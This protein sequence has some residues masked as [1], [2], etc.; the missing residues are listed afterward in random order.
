MVDMRI[1]KIITLLVLAALSVAGILFLLTHGGQENSGT[2][3]VVINE[4]MTKNTDAVPDENGEFYDWVELHNASAGE[5]D[6]S[7]YGFSDTKTEPTKWTFP[8]GTKIAA[9]GYLIVYCSGKNNGMHTNFKLSAKGDD[10]VLSDSSGN[11]IDAITLRSVDVGYTLAR[12]ADDPSQWMVSKPTPGFPNSD[13]GFA[14]YEAQQTAGDANGLYLNELMASNGDAVSDGLGAFSDWVELYNSTSADIDLS[15][16]GLSDSPE[17]PMRWKFPDGTSIKAGGYL[18]VYC[19]GIGGD[20]GSGGLYATF[21][22]AAAKGSVTLSNKAG[23]LI[24]SV[25][26]PLQSKNVSYGRSPDGTGEWAQLSAYTPGAANGASSDGQDA[27]S[28]PAA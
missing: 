24:D 5:I 27:S 12:S 19:N 21:A 9:D 15:G 25:E 14:E 13:A 4:V 2:N 26:Y 11:M 6:L 1:G 7:G 16:F 18:I 10:V 20:D 23:K 3:G 28:S 8:T 17:R 22:L